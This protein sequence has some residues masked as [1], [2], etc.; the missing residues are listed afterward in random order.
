[1]SVKQVGDLHALSVSVSC[2]KFGPND[3]KV[4]LR[5]RGQG[6][7]FLALPAADGEQDSNSH[8]PVKALRLYFKRSSLF[9][10]SEQLYVCFGGCFK[11]LPT[12]KQRLFR[13]IVDAIVLAYTSE[14][15]QCLIGVRAHSTRRKW[16]PP[17]RGPAE[18]L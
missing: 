18:L 8:C 3:C 13:W 17:G 2:L 14:G 12:T 7:I 10:Q 11:G 1:M 5:Q 16:P 4:V 15:L 9:R 6:I